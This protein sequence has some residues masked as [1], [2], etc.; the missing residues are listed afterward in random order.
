MYRVDVSF[1]SMRSSISLSFYTF[2]SI[3]LFQAGSAVVLEGRDPAAAR[4]T[5]YPTVP[6][7]SAPAFTYQAFSEAYPSG[8]TLATTP[9]IKIS[10]RSSAIPTSSDS[11][12][13]RPSE[14]ARASYVKSMC[15][16]YYD[17]N[18]SFPCNRVANTSR[19]CVYNAT[20]DDIANARNG[21]PR[22]RPNSPQEQHDCLCPGGKGEN[23]WE[24]IEG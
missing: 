4:T 21:G 22:L 1:L 3:N 2:I 7:F 5:A 6:S 13:S 24:Y 9:F 23:Y 14:S 15:A 11:R 19:T 17:L 16:P 18:L 12:A 8:Y 10:A 20:L